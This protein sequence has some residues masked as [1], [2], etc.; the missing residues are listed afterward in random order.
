MPS[1]AIVAVIIEKILGLPPASPGPGNTRWAR[2]TFTFGGDTTFTS[3][4]RPIPD[5]G[6]DFELF[7]TEA[8]TW[9]IARG[10]DDSASFDITI[11]VWQDLGDAAPIRDLVI[12]GSVTGP[13]DTY[14]SSGLKTLGSGPSFQ[15]LV[16]VQSFNITD[17]ASLARSIKKKGTSATLAITKG[18]L[19]ELVSI[20]GLYKP[21]P[22]AVAPAPGSKQV[23]GYLS[24]DD[25]GRIFTNRLPDGRWKRDTQYIEVRIKITAIGGAKF[26]AGALV[27]WFT[28]DVD[29]PTNDSPSFH[30]DWG[31]YVDQNDYDASGNPVGAKPADNALAYSPGN[32]DEDLLFGAS[33]KGSNRWKTG[34]GAESCSPI[35]RTEATTT[36]TIVSP[37]SAT[38]SVQVHCPNVLGTNLTLWADLDGVPGSQ[39]FRDAST[40]VM[41][42]W[43][44]LDVEVAR[45]DGAFSL[46]G[47]LPKIPGNFLP[48]CVQM[49]FQLERVVTGALDQN[50]VSPDDPGEENGAVTWINNPG[51]FSK[52]GTPGWFFIGGARFAS[53]LAPPGKARKPLYHGTKYKLGTA[54]VSGAPYATVV[55][56]ADARNAQ[57]VIIAWNDSG[58]ARE[59]GFPVISSKFSKGKTT[60]VLYGNDVTPLF[61]GWDSDGSTS[62]AYLS[63]VLFFPLHHRLASANA[64]SPGG[65]G[66]PASGATISVFPPG[67][68]RKTTGISP[69]AVSAGQEYFAGQTVIFTAAFGRGTPPAP[70]ANFDSRVASTIVHEF[71]HAFGMPHKCGY[72]NWKTPRTSPDGKTCCMNYDNTWLIDPKTVAA[73]P[74]L[75]PGFE[76]LMDDNVCGRHL[77]EVRRVHLELNKGLRW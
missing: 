8:V 22:G 62:H 7:T 36:L 21:D 4:S 2:A 43:S 59:A 31:P 45:M 27:H 40:G 5:A 6:G 11:E 14:K 42:M 46:S 49:D 23:P 76:G 66:V 32:T 73:N 48:I 65:F 29:D 33:A 3:R 77:M 25:K 70:V 53:P 26:P 72:W 15:V 18:F 30:R 20:D 64:M 24:R 39:V 54:V 19:L 56:P 12:T 51:V 16:T 60:I 17:L 1:T 50:T 55:V 71:V 68:A 38:S 74:T 13:W 10:A 34:P 63:Q 58:T 75:V 41:T 57:F 69:S 35:S 47:A 67:V 61:T 52:R 44:R 28:D 9:M 37:T